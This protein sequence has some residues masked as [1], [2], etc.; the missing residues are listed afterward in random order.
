MATVQSTLQATIPSTFDTAT[1]LCGFSNDDSACHWDTYGLTLARFGGVGVVVAGLCILSFIVFILLR[2]CNGC[3]GNAPTRGVFGGEPRAFYTKGEIATIKVVVL[4]VITPIIVSV[5]FG[6]LLNRNI[7]SDMNQISDVYG[8]SADTAIAEIRRAATDVLSMRLTSNFTETAQ[9]AF[10]AAK[11]VED[12]TN[13]MGTIFERFDIARTAILYAGFVGAGLLCLLAFISIC[14]NL[15][16]L[17]FCSGL[18]AFWICA[19]VWL[20]FAAH[21][22]TT[23]VSYDM[24]TESDT[25]IRQLTSSPS[26][27]NGGVVVTSGPNGGVLTSGPLAEFWSCG[28]NSSFEKFAALIYRASDHAANEEACTNFNNICQFH[29]VHC[30][31]D[32]ASCNVTTLSMFVNN[33]IIEDSNKNMTVAQCASECKEAYYQR[34][35]ITIMSD[36]TQIANFTASAAR[37]QPFTTCNYALSSVTRLEPLFCGDT[38]NTQYGV[39]VASLIA[40]IFMIALTV[41]L[42]MGYKRF[43]TIEP[44]PYNKP[45]SHSNVGL[46]EMDAVADADKKLKKEEKEKENEKEVSEE[47]LHHRISIKTENA[48]E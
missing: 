38:T 36:V 28:P 34:A 46:L 29:T 44:T 22:T 39:A 9:Q 1:R 32:A 25:F 35:C 17:S 2:A 4:V 21:F 7:S 45:R 24:C 31:D 41:L 37:V 18:V 42:I 20:T 12:R 11:E 48:M 33:T 13:D 43:T 6:L 10:D 27:Q 26:N 3:G 5:I 23:K 47:K 15:R 40:G 8:A 14:F 19:L 16:R 30:P